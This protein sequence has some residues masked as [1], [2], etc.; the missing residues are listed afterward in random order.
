MI[1]SS[2]QRRLPFL[3]ILLTAII[4][5]SVHFNLHFWNKPHRV[6]ASDVLSY[7]SYLPATFVYK[8][9]SFSFTGGDFEKYKY[10]FWL[11]ETGDNKIA[12]MTT[13]GLSLLWTPFFLLAHVFA[14]ILGFDADGYSPP[15]KFALLMS[16]L[17]YLVTGLYFLKLLL[18]KYF[19]PRVTAFTLLLV[20]FGTNL[21]H[22]STV[23]ATMSHVY[24]FSFICIFLYFAIRWH[25]H[26][27]FL[28]SIIT[29]LLLGLI[30]LIRPS[31]FIVVIVFLLWQV[32]SW[33]E[34]KMR[35]WYFI[36]SYPLVITMII[37]FFL[38]WIPQFIY[39]KYIS[40]SYF[41]NTYGAND[42]GFFFDNPQ[43]WS[44]LFSY[45]KGWIVYTPIVILA[46]AGFIKVNKFVPKSLIPL[47]IYTLVNIY[48]VSSWWCWW[49]GGSFSQRAFVDQY[50]IMALGWAAA[51]AWSVDKKKLIKYLLAAIVVVLVFFNIFQTI[52]YYNNAIH[53]MAMTKESYWSSFMKFHP[54]QKYYKQLVWPD[55]DSA[56]IGKY[57]PSS[58]MTIGEKWRLLADTLE[59]REDSIQYF[60]IQIKKDT[61]LL[62]QVKQKAIE[63]SISLEQMI[64]YDATW[65]Y[66]Q[67]QIKQK[68]KYQPI[69]YFIN[70][71]KSDSVFYNFVKEKARKKK[72]PL[73]EMLRKDAEWMKE[74][75]KKE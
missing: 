39:W 66:E 15:Y 37:S 34:I 26:P 49:Y 2:D 72:I 67:E 69:E 74:Q 13:M 12:V 63:R 46:F 65:L 42:A 64:E 19:N 32:S 23:E 52:Q 68:E 7:Y 22:Y 14:P 57:Y 31:N 3:A 33:K 62:N 25:E 51:I 53:Y 20:V 61:N 10:K 58:E 17:F 56:K 18:Q 54:T 8:D 11:F 38:V 41:F 24:S 5:L 35:I 55:Y 16:S 30:T 6:I 47:L 36:K 48:V 28:N 45:R 9:L 59:N 70:K 60:K 4:I 75:S 71:I 50:G 43:I 29:G 73:E 21:L 40:G 27:T 44:V 1:F